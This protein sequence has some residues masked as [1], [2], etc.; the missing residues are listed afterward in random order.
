MIEEDLGRLV[1]RFN[2][3]SEAT[4]SLRGELEGITRTIAIQL[5][6]E[7]TYGIDLADARLS[8][9]RELE[10]GSPADLTITTDRLTFEGLVAKQI[11]PM[12]AL[13]TQKLSITGSLEDKLL[14]RRLL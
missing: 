8:H 2:K 14:L 6:D 9:L 11:G 5:T 10:P 4:P 12:K 3:K 13:F 1:E 7:K